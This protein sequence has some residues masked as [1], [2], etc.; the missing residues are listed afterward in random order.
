MLPFTV[1][2]ASC[3]MLLHLEGFSTRTFI[4][5]DGGEGQERLVEYPSDLSVPWGA[6]HLC[7][8][9]CGWH[10]T[11]VCHA[12]SP[13]GWAWQR[14]ASFLCCLHGCIC[15]ALDDIFPRSRAGSFSLPWCSSH[16]YHQIYTQRLIQV[17]KNGHVEQRFPVLAKKTQPFI[18]TSGTFFCPT[19]FQQ[20]FPF[21][22]C[23]KQH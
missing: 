12:A 2:R 6:R 22:R 4:G 15:E 14:A 19:L 23:G 1:K 7:G 11:T 3:S 8:P 18:L 16:V 17:S 21:P 20:S 13:A 9:R 10:Q 5:G